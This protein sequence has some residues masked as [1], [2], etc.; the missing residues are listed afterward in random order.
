MPPDLLGRGDEKRDCD[1]DTPAR[2]SICKRYIEGLTDPQRLRVHHPGATGGRRNESAGHCSGAEREG[3]QMKS[4]RE[5]IERRRR[6]WR[7][8]A[9]ILL[10]IAAVFFLLLVIQRFVLPR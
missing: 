5:E 4:E 8:I 9:W 6:D 10:P 1:A 2:I 3:P 7:R